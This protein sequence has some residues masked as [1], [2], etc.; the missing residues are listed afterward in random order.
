MVVILA[1]GCAVQAG[2]CRGNY[3]LPQW[4]RIESLSPAE[5]P[6]ARGHTSL[7]SGNVN[8]LHV[9]AQSGV[10]NQINT[11]GGRADCGKC[12]SRARRG[13]LRGSS[14]GKGIGWPG[15]GPR[16]ICMLP[17]C[18][19]VPAPRG[20]GAVWVPVPAVRGLAPA[21]PAVGKPL[22]LPVHQ[23]SSTMALQPTLRPAPTS[24]VLVCAPPLWG[25]GR[26]RASNY[27]T[28]SIQ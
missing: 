24:R 4:L 16:R 10:R 26:V 19:F 3:W 5:I 28:V 15:R 22:G 1:L 18:S 23:V 17:T 25:L 6:A 2:R 20:G 7:P 11:L 9:C 14:A 8:D 27:R 21:G 13:W 12:L